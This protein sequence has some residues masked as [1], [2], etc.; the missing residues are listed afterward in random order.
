MCVC[1]CVCVR[2][3][4]Y[5]CVARKHVLCRCCVSA[6]L[7]Q[8]MYTCS[9]LPRSC[10]RE[11]FQP[12][13]FPFTSREFYATSEFW[14]TMRDVLRLGGDYSASRFDRA[15]DVSFNLPT[16]ALAS[17]RFTLY[18]CVHVHTHV[19]THVHVQ[20]LHVHSVYAPVRV[21]VVYN[22]QHCMCVCGGGGSTGGLVLGT[23]VYSTSGY[24]IDPQQCRCFYITPQRTQL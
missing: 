13:P 12:P 14:Y 17:A 2:A 21:T 22:L 18:T 23:P 1:V 24:E 3:C 6:C 10:Y 11:P 7:S 19:H 9:L 20:Y 4:V 5:A 8:L 15:A 16:C